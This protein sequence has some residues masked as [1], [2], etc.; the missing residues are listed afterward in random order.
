MARKRFNGVVTL[1]EVLRQFVLEPWS[2]KYEV[3]GDLQPDELVAHEGLLAALWALAPNL[4]FTS[5]DVQTA[6]RDVRHLNA[7][8]WRLGERA[9]HNFVKVVS[10][11]IRHMC[12]HLAQACRGQR[13]K[14]PTWAR[15][16]FYSNGGG[17]GEVGGAP[18]L[19]DSQA[20]PALQDSQAAPALQDSQDAQV[21]Q[22]ENEAIEAKQSKS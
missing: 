9:G 19:Q 1:V 12:R 21:A 15:G 5:V 4:S 2:I 6:L 8:K 16:H 10:A 22:K 11:R 7:A 17:G 18:A 20:V 3:L 14:W 13:S